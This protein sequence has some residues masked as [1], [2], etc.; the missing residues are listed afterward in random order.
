MLDE[1]LIF[2]SA[3]L[4]AEWKELYL[5]LSKIITFQAYEDDDVDDDD[6]DTPRDMTAAVV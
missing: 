3:I 1:K 6:D 4:S 2:K 5:S